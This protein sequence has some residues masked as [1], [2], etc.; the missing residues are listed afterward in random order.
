MNQFGI[1]KF[2]IISL[3]DYNNLFFKSIENDLINNKI[4]NLIYLNIEDLN[5]VKFNVKSLDNY[6]LLS[7]DLNKINLYID[8]IY[9][10]YNNVKTLPKDIISINN[11][12]ILGSIISII[13][14]HTSIK[15]IEL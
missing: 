8:S 1:Y 3:I 10:L 9:K 12:S 11:S 14:L 7:D 15:K 5:I 13:E 6:S 2:N 4:N